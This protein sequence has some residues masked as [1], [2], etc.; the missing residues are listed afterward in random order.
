MLVE[1]VTT[2]EVRHGA[3]ADIITRLLDGIVAASQ[4][5]VEFSF[6]HVPAHAND[7]WNETIDETAKSRINLCP[8][9]SQISNY[10]HDY[11]T[12]PGNSTTKRRRLDHAEHIDHQIR[13]RW[14]INDMAFWDNRCCMHRA[15]WDYWPEERKG[16]RVT[17]KGDRPH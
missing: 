2:G 10:L 1:Q 9:P 14:S 16:R 3:R 13:F 11:M 15:I 5:G 12:E 8:A 17:I 4:A 6:L 7:G